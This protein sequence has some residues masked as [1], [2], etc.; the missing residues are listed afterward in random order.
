MW[1]NQPLEGGAARSFKDG[2]HVGDGDIGL[3]VAQDQS[4]PLGLDDGANQL[5]VFVD[6]QF[7]GGLEN[8][9]DEGDVG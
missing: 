6:K 3:D 8:L 7:L 9:H 2:L 4:V 1:G 5:S